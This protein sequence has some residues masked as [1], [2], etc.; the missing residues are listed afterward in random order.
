[1]R[2][3]GFQYLHIINEQYNFFMISTKLPILSVDILF[4][5]IF[6]NLF[7]SQNWHEPKLD[8]CDTLHSSIT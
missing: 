3:D 8:V 1:M 6:H 4:F 5:Q 7:K 2:A